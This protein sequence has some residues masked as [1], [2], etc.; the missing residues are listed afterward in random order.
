MK[1][2]LLDIFDRMSVSEVAAF[3]A[4]GGELPYGSVRSRARMAE[5]R[6]W[7]NDAPPLSWRERED[8]ERLRQPLPLKTEAA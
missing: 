3:I 2:D 7:M 1:L 4:I 5:A 8:L 6:D